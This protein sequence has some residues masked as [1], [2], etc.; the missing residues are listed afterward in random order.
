MDKLYAETK[1]SLV[2]INDLLIK[3]DT[4]P[5][6]E[7]AEQALKFQ[8]TEKLDHIGKCCEQLEFYVNKEPASRRFD[9]KLKV[10]QLKYDFNHYKAA[11]GS[12]QFK[13]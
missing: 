11:F 7:P 13:K 5:P 8:I 9:V 6:Q 12:I 4:A 10:D 2:Q 1:T 3:F